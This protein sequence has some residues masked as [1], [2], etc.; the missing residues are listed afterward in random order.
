MQELA[1]GYSSRLQSVGGHEQHFPG[2]IQSL[3]ATMPAL[4]HLLYRLRS[5]VD[6]PRAQLHTAIWKSSL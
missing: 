5:T 1:I 2:M 4:V 6:V 3:V